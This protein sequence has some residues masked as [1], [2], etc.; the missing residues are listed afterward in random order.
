MSI[1]IRIPTPLRAYV[2]GAKEVSGEAGSVSNVLAALVSA[3]PDLNKH[4]F[5]DE[6]KVRS[7]VNVYLGDEDV[8]YLQGMDT[9]VPD[10]ATIS[11]VP[12][13]AGGR[14]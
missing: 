4:L 10:G 7:F 8:R 3:H 6:G 1:H 12:S 14:L 13:V 11:I 5:N 9:A 2:G